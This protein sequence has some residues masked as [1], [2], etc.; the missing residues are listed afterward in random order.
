MV[1]Q[2]IN[3]VL[4]VGFGFFVVWFFPS[5]KYDDY[6]LKII[7]SRYFGSSLLWC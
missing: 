5:E 7:E 3:V 2:I 4:F 6:F 1:Q